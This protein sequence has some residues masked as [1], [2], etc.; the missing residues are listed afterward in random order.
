MTPFPTDAALLALDELVGFRF[1]STRDAPDPLAHLDGELI[2][3]QW[4]SCSHARQQ[5]QGSH[6]MSKDFAKSVLSG[7]VRAL[8]LQRNPSKSWEAECFAT[9]TF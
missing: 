1:D 9:S 5:G 6:G 2:R 4:Q 7:P 3:L 8:G